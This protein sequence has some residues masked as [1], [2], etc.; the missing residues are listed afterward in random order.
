LNVR[1][2]NNDSILTLREAA[3]EIGIAL[4]TIRSH[5]KEGHIPTHKFG[6]L[7][8]INRTDVAEFRAKRAAG[9]HVVLRGKQSK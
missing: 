7:R 8:V 9:K 3:A 4:Q 6:T 1:I 2:T 5:I